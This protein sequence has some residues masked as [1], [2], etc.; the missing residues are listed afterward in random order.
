MSNT[1]DH[2][3]AE[4]YNEFMGEYI[5]AYDKALAMMGDIKDKR[6]LDQ[7]CGTGKSSRL[8]RKEGAV[9][10]GVDKNPEMLSA[11]R[12]SD[13]TGIEYFL[14]ENNDLA[15]IEGQFDGAFCTFVFL[16][17]SKRE[18]LEQMVRAVYDKLKPN[19]LYV[20]VTNN[21]D[22][23]GYESDF[24]KLES[25]EGF[26]GESGQ[27][28]IDTVKLDPPLVFHDYYWTEEDQRSI[29]ENAGFRIE[30][31]STPISAEGQE[32]SPF[33]IIHAVKN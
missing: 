29:L 2:R 25:G 19:S 31:I 27:S 5:V 6:V 15:G 33:M 1:Y 10:V 3:K 24:I 28:V 30:Q 17:V 22:A 11:T 4:V 18:E 13:A 26:T 23:I 7:G 20:I 16:E 12:S 32:I 14:I 9:V 8:L 21:P